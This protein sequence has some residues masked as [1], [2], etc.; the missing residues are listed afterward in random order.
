MC[1]VLVAPLTS[2][3][4]V[5]L[6]VYNELD[7]GADR[8]IQCTD[9]NLIQQRDHY[10]ITVTF[11]SHAEIAKQ[12]VH[13]LT[14]ALTHIHQAMSLSGCNKIMPIFIASRIAWFDFV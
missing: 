6:Y 7:V 12:Y 10:L 4:P 14:A 5:T 9:D 2:A 1:S 8:Q 11:I 13:P 3:G